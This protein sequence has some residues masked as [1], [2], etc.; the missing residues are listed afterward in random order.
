MNTALEVI[1][2]ITQVA[3]TWVAQVEVRVSGLRRVGVGVG[4]TPEVALARAKREALFLAKVSSLEDL[5]AWGDSKGSV[6]E[7]PAK[8]QAAT[9]STG[10]G[11]QVAPV[12]V[13]PKEQGLPTHRNAQPEPPRQ[14]QSSPPSPQQAK[15][16]TNSTPRTP[17][18]E[19]RRTRPAIFDLIEKMQVEHPLLVEEEM[20]KMGL[21]RLPDPAQGR[22]ATE[23]ASRLFRAVRARL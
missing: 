1:E 18:A 4:P 7:S 13:A 21:T 10:K 2:S 8:A 11:A 14:P 17:R 19:E 3:T 15:Q 12:Q 5:D 9:P 22:E 20:R 23:I 6:S 16:L